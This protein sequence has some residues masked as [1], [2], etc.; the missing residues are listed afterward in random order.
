MEALERRMTPEVLA[1]LQS[2]QIGTQT[3]AAWY[4]AWV[5]AGQEFGRLVGQRESVLARTTRGGTGVADVDLRAARGLWIQATRSREGGSD[6][7]GGD[8][9]GPDE[10]AAGDPDSDEPGPGDDDLPPADDII[11]APTWATTS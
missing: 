9:P 8:E 6:E 10:P 2:I 1:Q 4:L 7:E 11:V 5:A 3:L